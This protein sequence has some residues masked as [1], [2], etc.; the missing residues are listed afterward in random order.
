[1]SKWIISLASAAML[2][3][4]FSGCGG[5]DGESSA[6]VDTPSTETPATSQPANDY[7]RTADQ[8]GD[9]LP[10]VPMIPEMEG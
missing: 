10:A 1:M 2:A 3:F 9:T 6:A 4:A 5:S 7:T 8:F